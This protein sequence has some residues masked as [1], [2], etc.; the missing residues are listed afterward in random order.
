MKKLAI[1]G[2]SYGKEKAPYKSKNYEIWVMAFALIQEEVKRFDKIFE[3]HRKDEYVRDTAELIYKTNKPVYMQKKDDKVK[4]CLLFPF[5]EIF[6]KY[7]NYFTST[8]SLC[9]VFA[10][11]QGFKDITLYGV[12]FET[13]RE[14]TIERACIEY[15]IGYFRGQGYKINIYS[16]SPLLKSNYVYGIDDILK[17][18]ERI[19]NKID[20]YEKNMNDYKIK[21]YKT[22]KVEYYIQAIAINGAIEVL[23]MEL[24]QI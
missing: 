13:N 9:L 3:I 16:K 4:N 14:R 23:Q 7:G 12:N 21:Y 17:H 22:K 15:W 20:V 11:M 18:R 6:E 24:N 19:Q 1:V 5:D 10:I 8:W 2:T